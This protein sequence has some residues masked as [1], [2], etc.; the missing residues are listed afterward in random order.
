MKIRIAV[1]AL[2]L[3]GVSACQ[4]HRS[5]TEGIPVYLPPAG[6]YAGTFNGN[7]AQLYLLK[8]GDRVQGSITISGQTQS[9]FGFDKG[10]VELTTTTGP[11]M[12]FVLAKRGF[13]MDV[14]S[15]GSGAFDQQ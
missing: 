6:T 1:V 8:S 9:V 11:A 5:V 10:T 2:A 4:R 3:I 12:T 13:S 7:P 14:I 15:G